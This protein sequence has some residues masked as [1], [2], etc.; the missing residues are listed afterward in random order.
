MSTDDSPQHYNCSCDG[1]DK[2][3]DRFGNYSMGC[4]KDG[5]AILCHV[6]ILYIATYLLSPLSWIARA[7]KAYSAFYTS[8]I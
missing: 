5:L 8:S 6:S 3:I 7:L 4:E 1:D 2:I